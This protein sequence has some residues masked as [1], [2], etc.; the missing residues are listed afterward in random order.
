MPKTRAAIPIK[1]SAGRHPG[2]T[3]EP[4]TGCRLRAERSPVTLPSGLT[5]L[6]PAGDRLSNKTNPACQPIPLTISGPSWVATINGRRFQAA[7][8]TAS[9]GL[10]GF[11]SGTDRPRAKRN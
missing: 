10:S 4:A 8:K 3:S 5:G 11:K 6:L 9:F 7:M 2:A 1:T